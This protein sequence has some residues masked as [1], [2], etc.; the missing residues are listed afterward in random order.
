MKREILETC[1]P[2]GDL[3][4]TS[5]AVSNAGNK[6]RRLPIAG[7]TSA[8]PN[9]PLSLFTPDHARTC[10]WVNGTL[11]LLDCAIVIDWIVEEVEWMSK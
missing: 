8:N 9:L 3:P 6:M 5:L 1:P 11:P 7:S 2:H 10:S 4:A